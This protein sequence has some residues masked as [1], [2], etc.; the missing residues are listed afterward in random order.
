MYVSIGVLRAPG[1]ALRAD[2]GVAPV[3]TATG[4]GIGAE[5]SGGR[6]TPDAGPGRGTVARRSGSATPRPIRGSLPPAIRP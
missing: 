3:P 6:P 4:A 1:R 5:R 2:G